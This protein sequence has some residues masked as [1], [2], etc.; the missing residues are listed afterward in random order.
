MLRIASLNINGIRAGHR[1]GF[2]DWLATRGC[3]VVALQ[4]VRAPLD[5]L[6][7]S[8]F[9]DFH[10]SYEPGQLA[11]RNGVA[12]L[13][14]ERPVAVRTWDAEVLVRA[15]GEDHLHT[16]PAPDE[17]PLARG[18]GRH[19]HEGRYVEVD[20][21]E[22]PITVASLYL[23]KG[24][25]PAHLQKPGRM[26]EEPDGGARYERKMRFMAAFARQLSRTRRA[27]AARGREF[28]L[29]GDLNVAHTRLDVAAWRRSQ[30]AEGFLPEEREWLDAQLS[31]RTLVDVVRAVHP[32]TEGPYTWW[33]WLG[34]AYARDAGWRIDY[35]LAT[36]RLARTAV[37]AVVDREHHGV[38][39][40]DH[41]PVVVD[42][43]FGS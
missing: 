38:R 19:A 14:R 5:K 25:L 37:A 7:E 34:Q 15:L 24:G 13:T 10:V 9:G 12:V 29:M 6:P 39:L 4:E 42:Y 41:S 36:P 21:A 28:L 43:D 2:G 17:V 23:P 32:E 1:R 40:S 20:L 11:G 31:P 27:A 33:S 18:L 3:D 16:E 30:R 8:A 22:A 35:H 26:R